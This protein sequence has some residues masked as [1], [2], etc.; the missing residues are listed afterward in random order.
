VLQAN[1]VADAAQGN[2]RTLEI[3]IL[4]VA[5]EVYRII[6][7]MNVGILGIGMRRDNGLVLALRPAHT[8]AKTLVRTVDYRDSGDA[9]VELW[10]PAGK[11]PFETVV[12]FR[13]LIPLISYYLYRLDEWGFVFGQCKACDKRFVAK[14]RRFEICSDECRKSQAADSKRDFGERTKGSRQ[15]QLYNSAYY[16]WYNRQRKIKHVDSEK[17][18]KFTIAFKDFR[19]EASKRKDAIYRAELSISEFSNWLT[20]Q[21]NLADSLV[22]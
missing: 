20:E 6:N 16:Y 19:H 22:K 17:L 9:P 14:N 1:P 3:L 10:Y 4:S 11:R 7:Y 12:A 13:S 5:V 2:S 8:V 18:A 21:N 15:E